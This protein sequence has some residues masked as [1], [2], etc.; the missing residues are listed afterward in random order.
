MTAARRTRTSVAAALRRALATLGLPELA[1][2][3]FQLSVL[4]ALLLRDRTAEVDRRL[5]IVAGLLVAYLFQARLLRARPGERHPHARRV[6][7]RLSTTAFVLLTYFQLRWII[8]AL[9]AATFDAELAAIDQALYGAPPAVLLQPLQT[10]AAVEWFGFFYWSFFY[11][12]GAYTIAHC[13]F[14]RDAERF[15]GY[16]TGI[17]A[18]HAWGG[19]FGYILLP[20]FG[21][22]VHYASRLEP[23]DGGTFLA[24]SG[25]A[26]SWGALRDIFPSLHTAVMTFI[27]I[28]AFRRWSVH[29]LYK[30]VALLYLFWTLQIVIA[31]VFLRWHYTIDLVAGLALASA[32]GFASDRLARRWAEFRKANGELD[33]WF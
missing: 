23:L 3:S 24:M 8:P 26:Y 12:I 33:P 15:A 31:T 32:W 14:E 20:G 22:Y 11:V 13:I 6:V 4:V 9:H 17:V 16:G 30:P 25:T 5:P 7:R 18:V 21:P 29:R 1:L 19:W 27:T 28:H 10:F 2:A